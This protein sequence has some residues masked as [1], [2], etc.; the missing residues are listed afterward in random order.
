MG[1]L[2]NDAAAGADLVLGLGG[3]LDYEIV[4]NPDVVQSLVDEYGIEPHE[5]STDV[6]VDSERD[7]VCSI[8]GFLR[9]GV[10]GELLEGDRAIGARHVLEQAECAED[11]RDTIMLGSHGRNH[12]RNMERCKPYFDCSSCLERPAVEHFRLIASRANPGRTPS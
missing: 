5:A 4:W 7:L 10:G 3:C 12:N 6:E 1:P 8:L 2:I 11:G 9:E